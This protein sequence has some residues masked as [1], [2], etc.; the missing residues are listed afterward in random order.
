MTGKTR[1]LILAAALVVAALA[2]G[3]GTIDD[4]ER[5]AQVRA[6]ISGKVFKERIRPNWLPGGDRFWYRNDLAGGRREF[7]LVD[8]P[9]GQRRPAFDHAR[10]AEA[11]G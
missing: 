3:Q 4:Y 11:L 6:R 5:S 7:V 10:L 8:A 2:Q 1:L 9:K